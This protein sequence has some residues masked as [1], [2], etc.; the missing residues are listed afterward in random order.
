MK[1]T[2]PHPAAGKGVKFTSKKLTTLEM[3][4]WEH[5]TVNLFTKA[6]QASATPALRARWR[7]MATAVHPAPLLNNGSK[8]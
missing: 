3:R 4:H 2:Y 1:K 7:R 6:A 5:S 8:P